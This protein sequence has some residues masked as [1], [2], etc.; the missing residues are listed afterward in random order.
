VSTLGIPGIWFPFG[1]GVSRTQYAY[2]SFAIVA[3]AVLLR[4]LAASA[5]AG[6]AAGISIQRHEAID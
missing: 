5:R 3:F 4:R 2:A 6:L 1:V